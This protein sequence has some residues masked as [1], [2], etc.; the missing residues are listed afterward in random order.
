MLVDG[1]IVRRPDRL[2]RRGNR[3]S[4]GPPSLIYPSF[5]NLN[6]THNV[7]ASVTKLMGRHTAKAG[8]YFYT[9]YKA[10][11]FGLTGAIPFN[12]LIDFRNDT[13][14]PLDAGFP[15]AN[16]ALGI[17]SSYAQQSKFVQA[18]FRY[19]NIEWYFQDN[20]K[21]SNRL[22]L[23]Y[24]LRFTHQ[25]PQYDSYLASS[26]FFPNKWTVANAPL[27]YVPGCTT[28]ASPCP[29][30]NKTAVNPL[31]GVSLG[32]GSSLAIAT[33]V[34]NTGNP[35]NGVIQAGQGIAKENYVWPKVVLGPRVGAA[36]DL[37]GSQ[38][39]V[40]RGNVGLFYDRPEGNAD[41]FQPRIGERPVFG[42][43]TTVAAVCPVADARQRWDR[44]RRAAPAALQIHQP[45]SSIPVERAV[46]RRR[47]D[48]ASLGLGA[49]CVLRRQSRLQ[50]AAELQQCAGHQLD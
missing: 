17:F 14:N 26:N 47:A 24:G 41:V 27:L 21:V 43:A 28:A 25:Q 49:R 19:K 36:Y 31:T 22:T 23:D 37:T 42:F 13:N 5:L 3:I 29:T 34:P 4:N 33:L 44:D 20:W 1:R 18:A 46:E 12:G 8:L 45:M 10:E 48:C 39:F 50:H 30:A 32:A 2:D 40:F 7:S 35:P 11:N 38:K 16:A 6:H 15:Y 9:A